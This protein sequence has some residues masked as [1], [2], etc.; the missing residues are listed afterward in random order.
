MSIRIGHASINEKGTITGGQPGDQTGGEIAIRSW[1]SFPWDVYLECTDQKLADR[2]AAAMEGYCADDSHG[3][4]Q[5]QRWGPDFDCSSL[6]LQCWRDAG[7]DIPAQ[8]YTG[9][10]EAILMGTG[11]FRAWRDAAH[12]AGTALARRGGV[13][14]N[15][16]H[17]VC[18]ALDDGAEAEPAP[19]ALCSPSVPELSRGDTG[20]AVR[21]MQALLS[22]RGFPLPLYGA[23]GEWGDETES[24][25]RAFQAARGL[26]V[27]GI[28]GQDT[29][30]ALIG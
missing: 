13:Y 11:L 29:W 18:M 22:L 25:Q 12:T 26:A 21:A 14:L 16:L 20:E 15:T 9:N 1:Y 8:G 5:A 2:A 3:Y 17:H 27:D 4:D 10:M 6:V 30:A 23:D 7:L 28:T 19:A 24:A